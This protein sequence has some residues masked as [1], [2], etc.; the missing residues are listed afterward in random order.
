MKSEPCQHYL[1]DLQPAGVHLRADDAKEFIHG[2]D[3]RLEF[4]REPLN[5][6]D[7]N[8][9]AIYGV[10]T[11]RGQILRR[12]LG[13]LPAEIAADLAGV[14]LLDRVFPSLDY[15]G[16]SPSGWLNISYH[17]DGPVSEVKRFRAYVARQTVDELKG[18]A[19]GGAH[20]QLGDLEEA[21]A[22][23]EKEICG[24]DPAPHPFRR[25]L[26]IYGKL[27]RLDD[28]IRVCKR[29]LRVRER[30]RKQ[31]PESWAIQSFA[32]FEP[33][34]EKLMAKKAKHTP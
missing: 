9:L 18:D 27:K 4:E 12:K 19:P 33:R 24:R 11:H 8:A 34:L 25:L 5:P 2:L 31:C 26:V 32:D 29:A 20:E 13:Y 3:Q 14:G 16:V 22:S 15:S 1:T 23:Y 7:P 17:L 21:A 30:I 28:Q 6:H 10:S